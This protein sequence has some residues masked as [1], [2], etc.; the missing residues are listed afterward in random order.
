VVEQA[1][2]VNP[3][4]RIIARSHSEEET[5][6]LMRHGA[7]KVIMGEHLIGH[8]MVEEARRGAPSAAVQAPQP[9]PAVDQAEAPG[10]IG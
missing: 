10:A 7:N 4:L 3:Q 9:P 2:A 1:R 8:A 5:T 6:H